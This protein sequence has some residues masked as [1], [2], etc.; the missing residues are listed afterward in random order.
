MTPSWIRTNWKRMPAA[1]R[2]ALQKKKECCHFPSLLPLE[3]AN[4]F[5]V[6]RATS[7]SL[8]PSYYNVLHHPEAEFVISTCHLLSCFVSQAL[9]LTV[10]LKSFHTGLRYSSSVAGLFLQH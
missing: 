9:N 7:Q 6:F 3:M 4:H 2:E 5:T 8:Q 10:F 1:S